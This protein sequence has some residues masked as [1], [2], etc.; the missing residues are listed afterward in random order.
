M[1][2]VG[3]GSGRWL[4]APN[5]AGGVA[6]ADSHSV[7]DGANVIQSALSAF[8]TLHILINNAGLF[9]L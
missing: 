2:E 7:T 8:G 9:S 1:G 6:I 4:N 3:S 5:T